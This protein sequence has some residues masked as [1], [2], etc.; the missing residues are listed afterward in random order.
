MDDRRIEEMLRTSWKPESPDG[1][2]ERVLRRAR[3]ELANSRRPVLGMSRWKFALASL[4]LLVILLANI[5]D[6]ARQIRL[7]ATMH[8]SPL[9][10]MT[11]SHTGKSGL[12]TWRRQ[13][14]RSLALAPTGA[15]LINGLKGDDLL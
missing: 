5:S 8:G 10:K 9:T 12:L 1:M 4:G 6:H 15:G 11:A 7:S 3:G 13:I 14:E 2:R